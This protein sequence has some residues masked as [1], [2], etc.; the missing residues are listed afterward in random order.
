MAPGDRS[1]GKSRQ[2]GGNGKK[3]MNKK[4][5]KWDLRDSKFGFRGRKGMKKQN[6]AQTTDEVRG[7][8]VAL[9][10]K[11]GRIIERPIV[12]LFNFHR[13]FHFQNCTVWDFTV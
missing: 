10:T 4:E 13:C 1:G 11:R 6:T 8:N 3:E 9:E 2:S 5:K 12:I 7:F